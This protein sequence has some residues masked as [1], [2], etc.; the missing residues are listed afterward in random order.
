MSID[1]IWLD[2]KIAGGY[3]AVKQ[4][5]DEFL[6]ISRGQLNQFTHARDMGNPRLV[7]INFTLLDITLIGSTE[8]EQEF[9]KLLEKN[10]ARLPGKLHRWAL[11]LLV[12]HLDPQW[13]KY[14][15]DN[16]YNKGVK[17]G[18]NDIRKQLNNLLREE[19]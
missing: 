13:F 3:C 8:Q 19:I 2:P 4:Y 6:Y 5:E 9:L 10:D 17:A 18:R 16:A 11:K 7:V 1:A 15:L 14:I 12:T